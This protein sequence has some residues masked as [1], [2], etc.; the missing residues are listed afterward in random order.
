MSASDAPLSIGTVSLTVHDLDAVSRFYEQ[1]LGLQLISAEPSLR[2]FG[3][4]DKVL[5]ELRHDPKA[6][7]R[8]PAEAGLFHTAFLLPDRAD[9][10]RWIKHAVQARLAVQGASDHLVSEAIY[11]ADPEG[12]GIEIYADRP[13]SAWSVENGKIKMTTQPLDIEDLVAAA[14]TAHW[15][16][17]PEGG[18]IGHVHLQVG[19]LTPADQFY[20]DVLGLDVVARSPGAS[21]LSTGGYHHHLAANIWNSRGAGERDLPSTGLANVAMVAADDKVLAALRDRAEAA[22]LAVEGS[23]KDF[24]LRDP[25]KTAFSFGTRGE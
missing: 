2:R 15:R 24:S 4:G 25:W 8:S 11:L 7:R 16:G 18:I 12:N 19:A 22:G 9:L 6:R 5:L 13:R 21:F 23:G 20:G 17:Y 10:G 1:T 3:A 14:G